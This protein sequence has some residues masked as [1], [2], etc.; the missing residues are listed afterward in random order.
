MRKR[1][2]V[3]V[4]LA[5]VAAIA[6]GV[7]I[8]LGVGPALIVFGVL[9]LAGSQLYGLD[10]RKPSDTTAMSPTVSEG[11]RIHGPSILND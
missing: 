7:Y 4:E 10:Q 6:V 3:L 8:H 9:G 1:G 11:T 2:I 5:A